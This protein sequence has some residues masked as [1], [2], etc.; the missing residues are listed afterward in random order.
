[1][2][3]ALDVDGVLADLAGMIVKLYREETGVSIDRSI[4]TEW[5][6]WHK[7]S[8]TRQQFMEM[9]VKAWSRWFEIQPLE[10]DLSEDVEALSRIGV[11]DILTQRPAQTIN[12]VKQWLKHHN[13]RYRMFTWVPLKASKVSFVYDVY[14]DDSPRLAEQL[15]KTNRLLLLYDQP[16]NMNV[17]IGHNILR[18][19]SLDEA[20][21]RLANF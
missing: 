2:H 1:M 13:I 7:L 6:F 8:M 5:E 12:Y 15:Q 18:V 10:D 9:I 14:I 20:V 3:I 11:V 21:E 4:I 16:W 17:N 19:R